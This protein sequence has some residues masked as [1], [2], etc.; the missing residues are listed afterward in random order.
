MRSLIFPLPKI[1]GHRGVAGH[2]PENTLAGFY[3]AYELKLRAVE[4]D[5]RLAA[6]EEIVLFHDA[7]LDRTTNGRGLIR[8]FDYHYL[9]TLDAGSW[10]NPAYSNQSILRLIDILPVLQQLKLFP[11][12]DIKLSDNSELIIAE[13]LI[14]QLDQHW[15]LMIEPPIISSFSVECLLQLRKLSN[16]YP[17]ALLL[18]QY[19]SD[20]LQLCQQLQ[21]LSIHVNYRALTKQWIKKI[22][23]ANVL[24]L[25]YTVNDAITAKQLLN[26]DV[27]AVI[28]D[29]P[30]QLS[31]IL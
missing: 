23:Q 24:V 15:P 20:W 8:D 28:T 1:I 19:R 14:K 30:D 22:K 2:A 25:A 5:V 26:D 10:F 3:K 18:N 11:I 29:F 7:V 6:N 21:C 12:L 9:A 17:L 13:K 31:N 4:F 16:N 27:A